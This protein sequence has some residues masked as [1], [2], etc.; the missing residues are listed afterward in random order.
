M[1]FEEATVLAKFDRSFG[2]KKEELRFEQGTYQDKPTYTLRLYWQGGDGIWRW[3]SQKPTQSGK[4]WERLN[5]KVKE[6]K[7]L[8]EALIQASRL[9]PQRAAAP[10]PRASA[11]SEP[12]VDD[13]PF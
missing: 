10:Q 7:A 12:E 9:T 5:L 11:F 4:S 2:D 3:A 13:V 6:L 8:G 1:A